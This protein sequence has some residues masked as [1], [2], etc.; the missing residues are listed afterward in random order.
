MGGSRFFEVGRLY[1]DW[2]TAQEQDPGGSD[3]GAA[4]PTAL[5]LPGQKLRADGTIE[6]WYRNLDPETGRYL[7]PEPLL[8]SPAYVRRMAQTGMSVPTYAYAANNPLRHID[9]TGLESVGRD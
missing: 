3:S 1:S 7:S 8:Q 5:G 9:P 6:N 2:R 4:H